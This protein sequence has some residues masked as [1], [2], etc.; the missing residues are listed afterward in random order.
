M[1][2]G[3]LEK[4]ELEIG[5]VSARLKKVISAREVMEQTISEFHAAQK[6]VSNISF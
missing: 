4:G 6:S 5:Q 3:D 1:S 2:L